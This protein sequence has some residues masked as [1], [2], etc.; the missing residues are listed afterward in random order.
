ML[1]SKPAL[2]KHIE[3]ISVAHS[4]TILVFSR[5]KYSLKLSK[6]IRPEISRLLLTSE[7]KDCIDIIRRQ[8]KHPDSDGVDMVELMHLSIHNEQLNNLVTNNI[9]CDCNGC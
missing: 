8:N 4:S 1:S 6:A 7:V 5:Q 9:N 3:E 2:S